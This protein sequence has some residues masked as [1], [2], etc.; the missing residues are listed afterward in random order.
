MDT[1]L[2][3]PQLRTFFTL[4]Q[5]GSFTAC[6]R[7]LHRTQSAVSHAM[8]KLEDVAGTALLDRRGR[9]LVLT[10]E[11]R[12]LYQA[13]ERI[14]ATLE[15]AED[16]LRRSHSQARGLIRLGATVEFGS[17]ILMKHMQPF[18]AANPG[19][20]VDFTLRPDLLEPLLRDEVDLIIDCLEHPL[21]SLKKTPLFRETYVVA[22]APTFRKARRLR[23]PAD[24]SP[25]PIL[26][27][28]KAGT[29]WNRFLVS[30]PDHEQ[31]Q[32]DRILA[33]DHIRA[34]I[35]AAVAGMGVLL[36]P[37]Y[38]VLEELRRGDLVALFPAIRPA[39]DRFS[40]YQKKVRAGQEKLQLL[41]RY[42]QSLSP[43]EFGS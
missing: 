19:L 33:V 43:E 27:L 4:A 22:C 6:A 25:V 36:V 21:P 14:F 15:A 26:S 24:L 11:G 23:H 12:R 5:T 41:T 8:A 30:V 20:D 18:L 16:D 10:D 39:E 31:P 42:L 2:D 40:I 38:S 3:L 34:M 29:W 1:L 28:D 35:H 9:G 37:R 7:R 13:C 17:S 32:L